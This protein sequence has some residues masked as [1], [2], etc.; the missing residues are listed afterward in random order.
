MRILILAGSDH[1]LQACCPGEAMRLYCGSARIH[2]KWQHPDCTRS[3]FMMHLPFVAWY[4]RGRIGLVMSFAY[5]LA[6]L[7]LWKWMLPEPS[8]VIPL[9]G[10]AGRVAISPNGHK[11][12]VLLRRE[13]KFADYLSVFD[14]QTGALLA[15]SADLA[16]GNVQLTWVGDDL[17]GSVLYQDTNRGTPGVR[18]L[19]WNANTS[20]EVACFLLN[21]AAALSRDW[22]IAVTADATLLAYT[23]RIGRKQTLTLWDVRSQA[24]RQVIEGDY[25]APVFSPDGSLLAATTVETVPRLKLWNVSTQKDT[26]RLEQPKIVWDGEEQRPVCS[27]LCFSQDGRSLCAVNLLWPVDPDKAKAKDQRLRTTHGENESS[28]WYLARSWDVVTGTLQV[29]RF[30]WYLPNMYDQFAWGRTSESTRICEWQRGDSRVHLLDPLTGRDEFSVAVLG[31]PRWPNR[32]D[33]TFTVEPPANGATVLVNQ[34]YGRRFNLKSVVPY[35]HEPRWYQDSALKVYDRRTQRLQVALRNHWFCCF[36][37]DGRTLA[38]FSEG[39]LYL[40]SL[41][42]QP[43]W[44]AILGWAA[45]PAGLAG[46]AWMARERIAPYLPMCSWGKTVVAAPHR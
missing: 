2:I 26:V 7:C 33:P 3:D 42:S 28:P 24:I 45:L 38:T 40:W 13:D 11:L 36:A 32:P 27:H 17:V 20:T 5:T 15:Q 25:Q 37:D 43:R 30:L 10:S 44:G 34:F 39:R 4:R 35:L 19:L 9:D 12:V 23:T 31:Q 14:R 6:L 18:Y 29:Q 16:C 8:L 1:R 41:P 21:D 46:L 22:Y